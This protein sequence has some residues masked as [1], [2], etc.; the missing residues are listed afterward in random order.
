[1]FY[2]GEDTLQFLIAPSHVCQCRNAIRGDIGN[3]W[4]SRNCQFVVI[5]L[6]GSRPRG[7]VLCCS[8]FLEG[9]SHMVAADK[10]QRAAIAQ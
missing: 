10:R 2:L 7:P 3:S 1:M 8:P 6:D 9:G 4:Q 5:A